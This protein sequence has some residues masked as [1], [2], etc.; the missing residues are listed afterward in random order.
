MMGPHVIF[1]A[2]RTGGRIVGRV[3][4]LALPFVSNTV[5]T[6]SGDREP[7]RRRGRHITV[8]VIGERGRERRGRREMRRKRNEERKKMR[9]DVM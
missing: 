2:V 8:T 1:E 7:G 5:E 9:C 6:L 3:T 4:V